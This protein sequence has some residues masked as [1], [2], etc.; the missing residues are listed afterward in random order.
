MPHATRFLSCSA[1]ARRGFLFYVVLFIL[2]VLSI[3]TV[4]FQQVARHQQ[5]TAFRF[6]Q[7]EAARQIAEAALDEGFAWLYA[8]TANPRSAAGQ[9]LIDDRKSPLTLPVTLTRGTGPSLIRGD[10]ALD[11][12]AQ[13]AVID[14]RTTDSKGVSYDDG[15]GRTREGQ[16]TVELAVAVALRHK[17]LFGAGGAAATCQL[18][19]HHDFIVVPMVSPRDNAS[20]RRGYSQCFALD[21]ALFVRNGLTEFRETGGASLNH[22]AVKLAILQDDLPPEKRGK[23]FI[24]DTDVGRPPTGSANRPP[25]GNHVFLNLDAKHRGQIVPVPASRREVTIL[26][27]DVF[28]LMP[29]LPGLI[30][31]EVK[32]QESSVKSVSTSGIKGIFVIE[33]LP[34]SDPAFTPRRLELRDS[35]AGMLEGAESTLDPGL[36]LVSADPGKAA[37][38]AFAASIVEGA[39]RK[40]FWYLVTFILDMSQAKV[41]VSGK[42]KGK[43]YSKTVAMDPAQAAELKKLEKRSLCVR[44]VGPPPSDPIQKAFLENLPVIDR[45]IPDHLP[46]F[47]RFDDDFCYAGSTGDLM[48]P[49]ANDTFPMPRLYNS[50]GIPIRAGDAGS[51]GLRPYNHYNFWFRQRVPPAR[52]AAL[53]IFDPDQKVLNLRGIVHI[54]GAIELGEKGGEAWIVRGQGVLIADQFRI[55]GPLRKETADSLLV[56]FTRKGSIFVDTDQPVEAFLIASGDHGRGSVRPQRPLNLKG[57]MFVDLLDTPTWATTGPHRIAYDPLLKSPDEYQYQLNLSRW[58]TFQRLTESE[59]EGK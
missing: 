5:Q 54:Q 38:R 10:F 32:N 3:L 53:G 48:T 20:Q 4:Q 13:A 7:S 47:S 11:L 30:E 19:R 49:P 29:F 8:E 57:G 39:L 41:H 21:Y 16:G 14:F 37:D 12:K 50:R 31:K 27:E 52:L 58:V 23:V 9:W 25:L 6:E 43:S 51:E 46:F 22:P 28:T 2:V 40:R 44:L 33:T 26:Q 42:K 18:L 55:V 45:K 15:T 1:Q 36:E 24:G 59:E 17:G 56:L 34:M 35:I